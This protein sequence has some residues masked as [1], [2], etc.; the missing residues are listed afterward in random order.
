MLLLLPPSPRGLWLPRCCCCSCSS[1]GGCAARLPE[2]L[3][4]LAE[5][6]R[7]CCGGGCCGSWAPRVSASEARAVRRAVLVQG[8]LGAGAAGVLAGIARA[9]GR[10]VLV[11]RPL[12]ARAARVLA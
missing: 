12:L 9:V 1:G 4:P 2:Q 8:V 6:L 10:A 7:G 3:H 11:Q 5:W